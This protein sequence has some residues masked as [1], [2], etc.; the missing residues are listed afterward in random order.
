[1]LKAYCDSDYAGDKETRA[2]VTGYCIY[3]HGCLIAWKS[4]AQKTVSLS[5]TEAEYIAVSEVITEILYIKHIMDFLQVKLSLPIIV[6]C[7]NVGAIFLG[8]NAK[9]SPRTKHIG[10]R[11]HFIREHIEDGIVKIV[12][13]RSE[14]NDADIYTKNVGEKTFNEHSSKYMK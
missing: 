1:M 9:S 10:V 12:F 13:V 8:Y 4:R 11:Y 7:D 14:Q 2:S 5:S 3:L 6:N